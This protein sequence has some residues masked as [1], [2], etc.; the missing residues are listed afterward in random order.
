MKQQFIMSMVLLLALTHTRAQDSLKYILHKH[1]EAHQQD[2]WQEIKTVSAKGKWLGIHGSYPATFYFKRPDKYLMINQKARFIEAW[3]GVESWTIAKWTKSSVEDLSADK[4]MI[5]RVIF[6]FG[7]PLRGVEGIVNK[8]IVFLAHAPH[9]WIIE[10]QDSL[11]IEYFISAKTF[12]LTKTI[13]T[14]KIGLPLVVI[15]E[16]VKYGNFHN[17]SFPTHIKLRTQTMVAEYVFD[18]ITLGDPVKDRRFSRP[19]KK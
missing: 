6:S 15:R 3:D 18:K 2:L 17:F 13:F 9:Y 8:G 19:G 11:F 1:H 12:L 7:S 14:K 16:V 5:N 4:T 10:D